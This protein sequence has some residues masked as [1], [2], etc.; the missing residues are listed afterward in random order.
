MI[1]LSQTCHIRLEAGVLVKLFNSG[2]GP[3]RLPLK[4]VSSL[5]MVLEKE[6]VH[7]SLQFAKVVKFLL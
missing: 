2:F 3:F 6:V 4:I 7:S 5:N 1:K